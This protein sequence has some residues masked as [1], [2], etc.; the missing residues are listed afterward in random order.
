MPQFGPEL[1]FGPE[2]GQTGPES[3]SK[4]GMGGEPDPK[5][6]S[7]FGRAPQMANAFGP[8]PNLKAGAAA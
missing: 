3:G 8:V 5:S 1:R 4:F 7:G 2:P 6:G